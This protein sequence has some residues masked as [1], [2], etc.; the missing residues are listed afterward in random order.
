MPEVVVFAVKGRTP[1]Q[2]K[3]LLQRITQAVVDSFDIAAERVV[4]SIVE[5]DPE[6]KAKGGV[7]YSER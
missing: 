7:L 6:N 3:L 2:K 5:A 4:V 1:E